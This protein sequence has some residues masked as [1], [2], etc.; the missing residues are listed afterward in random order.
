[1]VVLALLCERR[2][3]QSPGLTMTAAASQ[4]LQKLTPTAASGSAIKQER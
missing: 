1:M 3:L 4:L 2:S